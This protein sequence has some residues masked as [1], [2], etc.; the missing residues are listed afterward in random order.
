MEV[1]IR[2]IGHCRW[3]NVHFVQPHGPVFEIRISE[4]YG[5]RWSEDGT[6]VI[7]LVFHAFV[8]IR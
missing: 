4:G 7:L 6:K 5:A 3:L 8:S 2:I 1:I